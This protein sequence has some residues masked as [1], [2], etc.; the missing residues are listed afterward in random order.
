MGTNLNNQVK[1][2]NLKGYQ[3]WVTNLS[4]LRTYIW[5]EK[6]LA[7]VEQGGIEEFRKVGEMNKCSLG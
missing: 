2:V 3:S 4:R 6:V 7:A 1:A 5:N